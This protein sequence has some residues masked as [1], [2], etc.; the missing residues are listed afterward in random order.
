MFL[1]NFSRWKMVEHWIDNAAFQNQESTA[2]AVSFIILV[3]GIF[4]NFTLKN[5]FLG[6]QRDTR[7]DRVIAMH[8]VD[9]GLIPGTPFGPLSA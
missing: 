6:G 3:K 9:Q 8:S 7:V 5:K 4:L 1:E 2:F